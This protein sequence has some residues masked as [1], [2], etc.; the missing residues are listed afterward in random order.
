[1]TAT[2]LPEGAMPRRLHDSRWNG[3]KGYVSATILCAR[4]CSASVH[5][6]L[7]GIDAGYT[8]VCDKGHRWHRDR[9]GKWTAKS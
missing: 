6:T 7:A 8:H 3:R 9:N 1:M 4:P 2:A 5:A